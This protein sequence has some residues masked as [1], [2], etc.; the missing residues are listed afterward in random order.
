MSAFT[1]TPASNGQAPPPLTAETFGSTL[2]WAEPP[3]YTGRPSPYY[4]DSHRHLR[5]EVRKWVEDN[6][7]TEAW[8]AAGEVPKEI[9]LKCAKDGLLMPI[10]AGRRIP[11]EWY[12]YPIIGGIKPE[13]WN[14]FHDMVLWDELYRGGAISSIFVG[15]VSIEPLSLFSQL[16]TDESDRRRTTDPCVCLP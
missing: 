11:K 13:E 12:G 6:V 1:T 14:G 10:A 8:E 16:V 15:L 7:D 3:W 9:Y 5:N 2:P 4:N